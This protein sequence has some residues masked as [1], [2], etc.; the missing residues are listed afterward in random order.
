MR[1]GK[2]TIQQTPYTVTETGR[3]IYS[4]TNTVHQV[5]GG[6]QTS[7]AAIRRLETPC[8]VSIKH[9]S[10]RHSY[11]SPYAE[12]PSLAHPTSTAKADSAARMDKRVVALGF[13][14]PLLT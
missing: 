13:T 7:K 11:S 1:F 14:R 2:G 5:G 8:C 3:V 10:H 12:V 4:A 9:T 6:Y